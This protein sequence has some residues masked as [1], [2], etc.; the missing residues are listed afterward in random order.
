MSK[1]ETCQ[2]CNTPMDEDEDW[3]VRFMIGT[4]V[5]ALFCR[6]CWGGIVEGVQINYEWDDGGGD[7]FKLPPSDT[8]TMLG[9]H[10]DLVARQ[11]SMPPEMIDQIRVMLRQYEMM[12][13]ALNCEKFDKA[14]VYL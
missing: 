8:V 13:H 10:M 11:Q 9:Q 7:D 5:Q 1:E 12:R 14:K 6:T 3:P 2:V 4:F